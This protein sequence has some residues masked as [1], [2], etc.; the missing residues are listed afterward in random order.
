M[1]VIQNE[2][3]SFRLPNVLRERLE[4]IALNND[5]HLSEVIRQACLTLVRASNNQS[6]EEK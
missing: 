5:R 4:E 1:R 2:V 6:R 3:I